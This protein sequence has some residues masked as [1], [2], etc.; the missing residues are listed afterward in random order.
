LIFNNSH[1]DASSPQLEENPTVS[2]VAIPHMNESDHDYDKRMILKSDSDNDADPVARPGGSRRSRRAGKT[3]LQHKFFKT[4]P[5]HKTGWRIW[6]L[7]STIKFRDLG[8]EIINLEWVS[9]GLG[10]ET[11]SAQRA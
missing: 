5:K 11:N 1:G 6:Q 3:G 9:L 7:G 4:F 8:T 2:F 10:Y